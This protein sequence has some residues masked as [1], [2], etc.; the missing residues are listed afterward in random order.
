[1]IENALRDNTKVVITEHGINPTLLLGSL[2]ISAPDEQTNG[3]E[4]KKSQ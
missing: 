4:V 3:R 2:P 1:M